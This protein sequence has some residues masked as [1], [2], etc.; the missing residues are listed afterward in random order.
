MARDTTNYTQDRIEKFVDVT[1]ASGQTVS[2]AVNCLGTVL[3]GIQT[4]AALTGT[5]LTFQVSDAGVTFFDYYNAA[6]NQVTV[7]MSVDK[8]IGLL[9]ADFAGIQYIKLVSSSAEGAER[10][11][12]L[13][14]RGM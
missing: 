11:F 9:P 7:A 13:I 3:V 1:I 6:G 5:S 8:R 14:F 4:P 12:T 10:K 2:N